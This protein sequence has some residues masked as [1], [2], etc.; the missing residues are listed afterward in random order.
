MP[1]PREKTAKSRSSK[2]NKQSGH[3]HCFERLPAAGL[4]M[5]LG[6]DEPLPAPEGKQREARQGTPAR[7]EIVS[8]RAKQGMKQEVADEP[9][10]YTEPEE[11]CQT[12]ACGATDAQGDEV[13]HVWRQAADDE[14]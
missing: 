9:N 14:S 3:A 8:N 13:D 7:Q 10:R 1:D 2:E 4:V 12:M 11:S 5:R 6:R